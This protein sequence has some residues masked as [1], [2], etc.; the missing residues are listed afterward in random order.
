M[1]DDVP[2]IRSWLYTPANIERRTARAFA[3]GA[4]A[5]VL[6]LEDAVPD[7]EKEHAR[8]LL[9]AAVA[10]YH[11]LAKPYVFA[12]I[13]HFETGLQED[14]LL[15]VVQAGLAGIRLPK[16][17]SSAE[18]QRADT[19]IGA[20]EQRAGL[21]P[22]RIRIV[23]NIESARGLWNALEI[24]RSSPRVLALAFGAVDFAR[25]IG[26]TVGQDRRETLYAR[27][28]LVAV[29]RVAQIRPPIEGVHTRLEDDEGLERSTAEARAL[30]FFGRS[31]VHPRQ[32]PII[33][34]A[35]TPKP[36]EV[37]DASS[38]VEAARSAG[39]AGDGALRLAG[40]DFID[41]AM[42]RRAEDVLSLA[43]SLPRSDG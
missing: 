10:Q 21:P 26:A 31:A 40:G 39:T 8:R 28:T 29:S 18:V 5:V 4:D 33:N 19:T 3:V 25:D 12:R 36:D 22:G 1:T 43:A 6:D 34:E 11:R 14:D 30:G 16:V 38:I 37:R 23:C 42:V 35:F 15:A 27:S 9:K 20:L 41:K 2:P 7:R 24:A 13:N 32:V 17:G